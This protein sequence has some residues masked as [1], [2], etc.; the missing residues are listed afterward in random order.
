MCGIAG[1]VSERAIGDHVPDKGILESIRYRGRDGDG[2][3]AGCSN[4]RLYHTRL[5]IIDLAH[6]A[7]PMSDVMG[8]Y[9]ITFNGEIYNFVELKKSYQEKGAEFQTDSDTEIIIHGYRLKGPKV[10]DDLNGMFAFA[11]WDNVEKTLFIARD[12]VGKKPL[13]W[14]L[15][16][17]AFIFSSTVNT[18]ALL[19]NWEPSISQAGMAF[20]S[21]LGGFPETETIFKNAHALPAASF[22]L[23]KPGDIDLTPIRYW[24]ASYAEKSG[25]RKTDLIDEY[26]EILSNAIKIRMRADVPVALSFSGGTDSGTIAAL[27]KKKFNVGLKCYTIDYHT[28]EE[29]SEEVVIAERVANVIGLEWEFIPFDYRRQ[30]LE[31][32]HQTYRYFDQP[33]QQFALVYSKRLYDV[34]KDRCT[35][36]LTGNGADELFLGYGGDERIVS[37]DRTRFWLNQIPESL[38]KYL[39]EKQRVS[40]NNQR[41][42]NFEFCDWVQADWKAYLR[43]YTRDESALEEC[44][45]TIQQYCAELQECGV[46]TMADFV[47]HRG[48]AVSAGDT[49]Y[50][51]PDITGYAAQVEVRSPFLDYRLIEFA[52]RLPHKFKVGRHAGKPTPKIL[53]RTYYER[54][55]GTEFA[56]AT[57]KPMGAN[58]NWQLE[59]PRSSKFQSAFDRSMKGIQEAGFASERFLEAYEEFAS[60]LERGET[61]FPTAGLMM[62]GFMLGAWLA[63][64]SL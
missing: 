26:E 13:F 60:A 29:P 39:P 12:R 63:K 15:H 37:F 27:A 34:M 55:V 53:P 25:R 41:L 20:Y 58:L 14:T 7:Q 51:L 30:M 43:Q 42:A 49:N 3:W 5:S 24:R 64:R 11:I 46:E 17:G 50:R 2:V 1:I 6:G 44:E 52:A 19:P 62:N 45:D 61:A 48:L 9:V 18:F 35:V 8:R 40:W 31:E 21:F 28:P 56:W 54:H 47:M 10:L 23:F 57:K 4:A 59:F 36:V 38:F 33:C 22:A 16:N 32:F